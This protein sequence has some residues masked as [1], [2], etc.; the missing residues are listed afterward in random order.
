MNGSVK[1]KGFRAKTLFA[2]VDGNVTSLYL[3]GYNY[4]NITA[5]G[6]YE[7]QKINGQLLVNDS[8]LRVN[9]SGFIN[10][11][12]DTPV[13]NVTGDVYTINFKQLGL[14]KKNLQLQ[15]YV[16]VDFKGKNIDDFLGTANLRNAVLI[17]DTTQLSFDYL[18]I[19]SVIM[20]GK[21]RFYACLLYT[22][23]SPRD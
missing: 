5:K 18:S 3:N 14:T 20:D 22:S 6:A 23:P 19:S 21:K 1:G 11:S 16:D 10:F 17:N 13:Y 7:K 12:K 9:L 15:S 4:K 2:E 8:N